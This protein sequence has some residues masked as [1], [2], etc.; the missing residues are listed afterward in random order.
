[1]PSPRG[2]LLFLAIALTALSLPAPAS[3]DQ[4]RMVTIAARSCPTYTDITAN[5]ARN[6]IMESLEDLG[7]DTP[8]GVNGVPLNVD[9]FIE[10]EVQPNCTPIEN[11][12]FTLGTGYQTRAVTGV[13]G[14]L[15]K[16]TGPFTPTVVT[17]KQVPLR[18]GD[19]HPYQGNVH[20]AGAETIHLTK[21]QSELASTS[22]KLWIQGG[23]P[24]LPITDPDAY[25][26]GALRCA[27]DNYN[28][29]NVEW[30]SY[31]PS[32]TH[33]FCFAYYVKPAPTSGTITVVKDVTLPPETGAQNVRFTGDISY[34]N[35]E[36]FLTASNGNP[37]RMS[38]I[39]AAGRTWSFR[40]DEQPLGTLTAIDCTS[41]EG[42]STFV[43]DL[44]TRETTVSLGAGD[45]V[46]CTYHNRYRRPPAGLALRKISL[47]G[48]GTFGFD[49]RGEGEH[50][51]GT[52]TTTE[53][54]LATRVEPSDAIADLGAGTYEVTEDLP[55]NVGGTWS[56]ERVNCSPGGLVQSREATVEIDVPPPSG[57][58][59]ICTFYN[60]FVPSGAIRLHKITLDGTATTRFQV[61]PEFGRTRPEREQIATTTT[62]G[63]I[64][65]AAGDDLDQLPIGEY[66]IQETIGG[67]D[68]WELAGVQCDG[69]PVP[70]TAGRIVIELTDGNPVRDCTFINRRIPD[71]VPPDP[72]PPAPVPPP[73]PVEVPPQG[74]IAGAEVASARANLLITKRVRPRRV[75]LGG[76]LRYRIVVRNQGPDP[77]EGVTVYERRTPVRRALPV[78]SNKGSCRSRPPRYCNL[79]TLDPGERAV[80][81]VAVRAERVGRFTNIVAVNTATAQTSRRGK[82]ASARAVVVARP[83]P[84]FTG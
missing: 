81:R 38:F 31:P 61:R 9:P 67:T 10:A 68:R 40:E 12:E 21:E 74:G 7:P 55:P 15:S 14:A 83:R 44:D 33:V 1:M 50:L 76:M 56:L 80:I 59:P 63:E 73:P 62:P 51:T 32:T 27:T 28:G 13:W 17:K 65:D 72:E 23:T 69:V 77:A 42:T 30:I 41:A 75:R 18:D 11:W 78:R 37:G 8:Y 22:S 79:G 84:R 39:R 2:A 6:N 82:R 48:L 49:I 24:T 25:A 46:T 54:R 60:R 4:P 53:P 35:G 19:G 47:G 36:F 34:Q 71:V 58:T 26:F 70:A 64:A 5:R 45:D 29:D 52:A 66:S 20:I 3:A 43:R 16:V 57:V